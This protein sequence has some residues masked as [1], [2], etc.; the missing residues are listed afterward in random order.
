MQNAVITEL[1]TG[2][3]FDVE[4]DNTPSIKQDYIIVFIDGKKVKRPSTKQIGGV[5]EI[6]LKKKNSETRKF[7]KNWNLSRKKIRIMLD[8][9]NSMFLLNGC[10]I[11]KMVTDSEPITIYY[12]SYSEA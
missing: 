1:D 4:I 7:V 10:Y 2:L 6:T 5:I 11:K 3:S 12:N 8:C 9:G